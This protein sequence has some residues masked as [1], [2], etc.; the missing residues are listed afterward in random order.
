VDPVTLSLLSKSH[1][2][3]NLTTT[4]LSITK[5][6][7]NQAAGQQQHINIHPQ[8]WESPNCLDDLLPQSSTHDAHKHSA[9][10][11][12]AGI[13]KK[14]FN[15][16]MAGLPRP[17]IVAPPRKSS[18]RPPPRP[19]SA[20]APSAAPSSRFE[21]PGAV[22]PADS[23]VSLA[24]TAGGTKRKERDFEND[25]EE[26]NINVVVRCRG[27]NEREVRENS[28]VVLQTEGVKGKSLE[29]SMGPSAL[30]NKTY[31]FDKVFSSAADQA[32]IYDDVVIPIL[33]EVSW[34][35]LLFRLLVLTI[36]RC[37]LGT[38][39]RFSHMD[40]LEPE[41]LIPCLGT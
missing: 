26:T 5:Q 11:S 2:I 35:H 13:N 33:D 19:S 24:T 20:R 12:T 16:C 25:E 21:R 36:F 3:N 29:L 38:I 14:T 8:L 22:S 9:H 1:D 39:A 30:S 28:G 37:W 23:V 15:N 17:A 27:R 31:T 7:F 18:M 6:T 34:A 40:K 4:Q 41:R 32:M 10:F